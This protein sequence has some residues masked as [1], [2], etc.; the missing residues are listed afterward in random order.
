MPHLSAHG[1]APLEQHD[2][3][4]EGRGLDRRGQP[5]NAPADDDDRSILCYSAPRAHAN[6]A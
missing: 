2:R 5:T 4:A 1:G 3:Q 6:H